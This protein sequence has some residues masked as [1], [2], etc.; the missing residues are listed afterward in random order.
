M[1]EHVCMDTHTHKNSAEVR[2]YL[3]VHFFSVMSTCFRV[4]KIELCSPT[5]IGKMMRTHGMCTCVCI[6]IYICV[7]VCVNEP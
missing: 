1:C 5:T 7:C 3:C 4:G 2:L 6:Y